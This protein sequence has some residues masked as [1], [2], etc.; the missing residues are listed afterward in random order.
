MLHL[1]KPSPPIRSPPD[2]EILRLALLKRYEILDTPPEAAFDR[3]TALAA[4][5]F[6]AP[7]AIVSFLDGHRLWFKSHHGLDSSEVRWGPETAVSTMETLIRGQFGVGFFVSAP[8][9]THDG[10]ELGALCVIDHQPRAVDEQ[11]LRHLATLAALVTDRM[12]LRLTA[13]TAAARADILASEVDHRAMNS[14]QLVASLLNLQSRVT[15]A[16]ETAQQLAIAANR[17]LAVARVHRNFSAN[18][19]IECVSILAYLRRLCGELS[20]VLDVAIDVE[21]TEASVPTTQVLAI[22]LIVNELATNAKK[23]G[24]GPI[25]V[26]FRAGAAGHHELCILDQGD[27]LPEGFA[28]DRLKGSGLGIKVV[29]VLV[30]QL[31]GRLSTDANPAG[32]GACFTVTFPCADPATDAGLRHQG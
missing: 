13:R 19:S 5:L 26:T 4:D 7:I 32:R 10:H 2:N 29:T 15:Q 27:G 3:I 31:E 18:E 22:G 20:E 21:G 11:S 12:E 14:L 17:V 6:D 9:I 1:V 8:L 25:K 30:A 23:H 24:A 28:A 16:P